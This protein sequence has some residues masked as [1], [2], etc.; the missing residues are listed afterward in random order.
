[1]EVLCVNKKLRL[2]RNSVF[3][4]SDREAILARSS[5]SISVYVIF[6]LDSTKNTCFRRGWDFAMDRVWLEKYFEIGLFPA[7]VPLS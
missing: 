4:P 2:T 3:C 7:S 6:F 1:M 5:S